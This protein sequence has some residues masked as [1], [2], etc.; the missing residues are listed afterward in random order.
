MTIEEKKRGRK[1]KDGR[2]EIMEMKMEAGTMH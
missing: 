1:R 2:G